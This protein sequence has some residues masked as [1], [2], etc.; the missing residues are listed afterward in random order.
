MGNNTASLVTAA[1]ILVACGR[2]GEDIS[3]ATESGDFDYPRSISGGLSEFGVAVVRETNRLGI[4]ADV[5]HT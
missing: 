4:M 3:Q 2:S 1:V 5:S